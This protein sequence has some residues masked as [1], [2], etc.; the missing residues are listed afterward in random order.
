MTDPV[1]LVADP[2]KLVPQTVEPDWWHVYVKPDGGT[3]VHGP[4][5]ITPNLAATL[6]PYGAKYRESLDRKPTP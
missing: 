3:Y 4:T 1:E 6:N 2:F 5:T